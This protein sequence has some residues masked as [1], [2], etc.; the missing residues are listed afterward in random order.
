MSFGR[1]LTVIAVA[2]AA[3]VSMGFTANAHA[4][5][6]EQLL[7]MIQ[8][9][10]ATVENLEGQVEAAKSTSEQAALAAA[11]ASKKAQS[12]DAKWKWGPSPTIKSADGKFEMHVRGR[13]MVD[14]GHV[15]DSEGFEDR[16]A[17][18]F[19]R[20]RLGIEGKAWKDVKYKFE[21]DFADNEV[22]ITDAYLQYK[23]WKN[24][25]LTVGQFK[26]RVS[27][28]EQTT[29]RQILTQ[30]RAAFT[31]AFD[32]ARRI[33]V[34]LDFKAGGFVLSTGVYGGA[35]LSANEDKEGYS[36]AARALYNFELGNDKSVLHVGAS[37]RHRDFGNDI[38]GNE[39]RYRQRP[40]AHVAGNRFVSTDTLDYIANDTFF[41]A[42]LAGTFG[43]FHASAEYG[44]L[45]AS[46]E[47][48]MEAAYNGEGS[49][50]FQGGYIDFGW[51][52][53][54]EHRPLDEGEWDRPKIKSPVFEGGWGAWRL[55]A[56]VDYLDLNDFDAGIVGG[57]QISYIVGV[58]WYLNRHTRIMVNYAHTDVSKGLCPTGATCGYG[59]A[60]VNPITG[61]NSIDAIT[62]RFQ[63]DW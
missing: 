51:F 15:S 25:A 11:D 4:Q 5:S 19:R 17:T 42:E 12:G 40:F 44:L 35:D 8:Q 16:N 3:A 1:G 18:E 50:T 38:D 46:I 57:R 28:D 9:L 59:D 29:S 61:K 49:A 47:N 20:A 13:L 41:G 60:L 2:G 6:N 21:I 33:G 10:S 63:V 54:G 43:P 14:F 62:A 52:L 22:S 32:F 36:I 34:G 58:D 24:V 37:F 27:L 45:K 26:E 7:Q 23:G 53:T 39:F 55:L 56:R 30:E 48:G 31:D